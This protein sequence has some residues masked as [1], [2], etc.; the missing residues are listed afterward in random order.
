MKK[1]I[2]AASLFAVLFGCKDDPEFP[3]VPQIETVSFQIIDGEAFWKFSFKDGDG[4][5]GS[6]AVGDT[7]FFHSMVNLS[8]D[9]TIRFNGEKIPAI[10]I[11]GRSKGIEG[12]ITRTF[13][14]SQYE[15][16]ISDNDTVYFKAFIADNAGNES[17]TIRT[18]AFRINPTVIFL[19]E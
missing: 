8:L 3:N 10:E 7:N 17:N 14:L 1:L 2:V 15:I 19:K 16:Y 12:E 11:V 18:P 6:N 9:T 5:L 4:D 13:E